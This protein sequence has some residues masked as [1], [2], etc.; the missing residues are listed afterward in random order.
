MIAPPVAGRGQAVVHAVLPRRGCGLMH[1]GGIG[2][3]RDL[4]GLVGEKRRHLVVVVAVVEGHTDQWAADR[5]L[6]G[7]T[8]VEIACAM[9]VVDAVG[10]DREE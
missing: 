10:G 9:G 1:G 2:G 8:E 5:V 3:A 4:R 6:V 7:R